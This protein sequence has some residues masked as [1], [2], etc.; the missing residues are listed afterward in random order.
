MA[1][2]RQPPLDS[3]RHCNFLQARA[4]VGGSAGRRCIVG[5]RLRVEKE[6]RSAL[7]SL[8]RLQKSFG[9]GKI[10]CADESQRIFGSDDRETVAQRI[11][12]ILFSSENVPRCKANFF[13]W[14]T[15]VKRSVAALR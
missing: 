9:Y 10:E 5:R 12:L 11:S 6:A 3:P 1:S 15:G 4:A 7:F 8:F 2:G 14:L 13:C